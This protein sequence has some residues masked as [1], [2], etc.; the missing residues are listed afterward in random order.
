MRVLVGILL[1]ASVL[2]AAG[3]DAVSAPSR[4]EVVRWSPFDSVGMLRPSLRLKVV[5]RGYCT[6]IGY[7]YVGGIA[8]RCDSG[9]SL[10]D[11]CWRDGP[12]PT[13]F[14][15]CVD[16]PWQTTVWR[17]HSP[18]L[19]LY[20]GVTFTAAADYPWGIVLKEGN[21]CAV[22]QGAHD[23]LTAHGKRF[24]VDYYCQR[25]HI[26]LLREGLRRG[27]VWEANAARWNQATNKYSFLGRLPLRRVYFGKL[28]RPMARQN[29]LAHQAFLTAKRVIRQSSPRA[30]LDLPWVRLALPSADW[31]Y[32]IFTPADASFRGYFAVLHRVNGQWTNASAYKP[33]CT[34]LP[35]RVRDQLFLGKKTRNPL[36]DLAPHGE[37]RC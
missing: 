7:T 33:Y 5:K 26:V 24:V 34:M 9:N 31:A 28:P 16:T 10:Y 23:T 8:Y 4:T 25:G 21:R 11:A 19:L 29:E 6:D 22:F 2:A 14:V 37:T 3:G 32:V 35:R 30:H 36:P 1:V 13:E 15:I 18:H 27:T 17:L 12:N 20:P